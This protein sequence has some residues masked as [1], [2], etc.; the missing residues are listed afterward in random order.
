MLPIQMY[1]ICPL[2]YFDQEV[3]NCSRLPNKQV[4]IYL[5]DDQFCLRPNAFCLFSVPKMSR[6]CPF[7]T[8]QFNDW[9]LFYT[10]HHL[11][12]KYKIPI[13]IGLYS[14]VFLS[15]HLCMGDITIHTFFSRTLFDR[16]VYDFM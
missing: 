12:A 4:I 14:R 7:L 10:Y 9:F 11:N 6:Y 8:F 13:L 5:R 1:N 16:K 15:G 3:V 2:I